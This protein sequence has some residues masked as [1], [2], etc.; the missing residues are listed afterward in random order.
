MPRRS[1]LLGQLCAD[2]LTGGSTLAEL[3]GE[4]GTTKYNVGVD[5][6][7]NAVTRSIPANTDVRSV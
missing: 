2:A 4:G 3:M 7:P 6:S 5:K 1:L